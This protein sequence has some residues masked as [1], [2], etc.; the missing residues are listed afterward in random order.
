[1]S[2]AEERDGRDLLLELIAEVRE[3][4]AEVREL[5]GSSAPRSSAPRPRRDPK[6][7]NTPAIEVSDTD[8]ARARAA[9]RRAGLVVHEPPRK[10]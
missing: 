1:M 3:L 8:R 2:A 7:E 5:K 4:R 9:A 6:P 10:A